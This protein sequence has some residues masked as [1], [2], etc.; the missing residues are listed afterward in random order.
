MK[1][2]LAPNLNTDAN[3]A[4]SGLKYSIYRK[5]AFI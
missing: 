5:L 1:T 2:V 4:V 3:P